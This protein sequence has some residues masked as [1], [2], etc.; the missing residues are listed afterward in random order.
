[1]DV[2][3][4]ART[5]SVMN[6]R[7][8]GAM[9]ARKAERPRPADTAKRPTEQI[10]QVRKGAHHWIMW[11]R[12]Y[13]TALEEAVDNHIAGRSMPDFECVARSRDSGRYSC[14]LVAMLWSQLRQ[15]M[16]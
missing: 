2:T 16:T 5:Q 6:V 14:L 4:D 12:R 10:R 11:L 1:M 3:C 7:S 8:L 15:W 13:L 9:S